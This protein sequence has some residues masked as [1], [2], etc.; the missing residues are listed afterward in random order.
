MASASA[1]LVAFINQLEGRQ[2]EALFTQPYATVALLRSLQ[3]LARQV[4]ARLVCTRGAISSGRLGRL[5]HCFRPRSVHVSLPG[6]QHDGLRLMHG[7]SLFSVAA[8]IRS[9][10]DPVDVSLPDHCCTDTA[11][12]SAGVELC[13]ARGKQ[14]AGSSAGRAHLAAPAVQ[15]DTGRAARVL[16]APQLPGA[17]S[18]CHVLR[19]RGR[20]RHPQLHARPSQLAW[21]QRL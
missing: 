19:V 21:Q 17:A 15:G 1:G 12:C 3:P 20:R 18:P 13:A 8:C 9:C 5:E 7:V 16:A 14:Q 4:L 6:A 2:L 11:A 10:L